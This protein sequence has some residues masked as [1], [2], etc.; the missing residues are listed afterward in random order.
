MSFELGILDSAAGELPYVRRGPRDGAQVL[1]IQ[2]L[3]EEQNRLRRLLAAVTRSLA[4]RG[5]GSWMFDLPGT[6]DSAVPGAAANWHGWRD[7][8]RAAARH[9]ALPPPAGEGPVVDRPHILSVR[10]GCLLDDVP[11][12]SLYRF[13]P[14]AGERLLRELL[15]ARVAAEDGATMTSLNAAIDAGETLDLA[16]YAVPASLATSL[17]TAAPDA[18]PLPLRTATIGEGAADIRLS[19]APLWRQAEP[20]PATALAAALAD[21]LASWMASCDAR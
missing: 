21:D 3:F 20:E 9:V 15:R 18:L 10:G 7:A 6:G 4:R 12:R 14:V 2:P 13:A 1:V 5:I 8:I 16:G 17:R 11:G 19:G